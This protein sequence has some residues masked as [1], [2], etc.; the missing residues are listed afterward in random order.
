MEY[1]WYSYVD[2][3]RL[4]I[5]AGKS[6]GVVTTA[7]LT[8]ATPASTYAHSPERVW[9]NDSDLT[10]AAVDAGCTDIASQFIDAPQI[11]VALGG[12]RREFLPITET[13]PEYPGSRGQ[14]RDGRNLVE[15]WKAEHPANSEFV[16]NKEQ[17]DDVDPDTIRYL[18]GLFETGHM[19]FESERPDDGA[20]EPS[21]AEMT[22]KA[23]RIL[24]KNSNGFFLAVEGARVDHGHHDNIPY[25]ALHDT[26]AMEAAVQP[27]IG[28]DALPYTTLGYLNGPGGFQ[29]AISFR[30]NGT[31][32]NLRDVETNSK[33]H[34]VETLVPLPSESHSGEDVVIYAS[35]PFAHLFHGVHEQNYIAHVIRYA[36]CLGD[37]K[38]VCTDAVEDPC[39]GTLIN[40]Y[41]TLVLLLLVLTKFLF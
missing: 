35:G 23:I 2:G 39:G 27:S 9:E 6:T 15:E 17:F 1:F 29:T 38:Q 12:G 41:N 30:N 18:F 3:N 37:G 25:N 33:D 28:G 11:N 24:S 13:D 40:S 19:Q 8:H 5:D 36:A 32:P 20:G 10:N 14:R 26:L 21:I 4:A 31:R 34:V 22:D 16:W 7:R